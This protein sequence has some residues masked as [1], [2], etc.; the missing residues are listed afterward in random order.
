MEGVQETKS[1]DPQSQLLPR[2]LYGSPEAMKIPQAAPSAR[3]SRRG[4]TTLGATALG[5]AIALG[6]GL[7]KA[8]APPPDGL[9]PTLSSPEQGSRVPYRYQV[10]DAVVRSRLPPRLK[11]P[12]MILCHRADL[13]TGEA[14]PSYSQLAEDWSVSRRR[15]ITI[16][17]ELAE[18][19]CLQVTRRWRV[20][21]R[22]QGKP[23]VRSNLYRVQI[24]IAWTAELAAPAPPVTVE[25]EQVPDA[26]PVEELLELVVEAEQAPAELQEAEAEP[27]ASDLPMTSAPA[28]APA[29]SPEAQA[30]LE[31]LQ[32]R[33]ELRSIAT[34]EYACRFWRIAV[35]ENKSLA[36]TDRA[37]QDAANKAGNRQGEALA[38]RA[39]SFI[40]HARP[41]PEQLPST[42]KPPSPKPAQAA[43]PPPPPEVQ[44]RGLRSVLS[45]L[46]GQL[47]ELL[48]RK[49]LKPP[50]T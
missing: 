15:A 45:S 32:N 8:T 30:V 9:P 11:G 49:D 16:V 27:Q 22:Q 28:E 10:Q 12:L 6:P 5:A 39:I 20:A 40:T 3:K 38:D 17:G 43:P 2:Q 29:L 36:M 37:L 7:A 34:E 14:F 21:E 4:T 44:L 41:V 48:P 46:P 33:D 35:R 19:E 13:Y 42:I 31:I 1:D 26:E 25:A 24:P 47:T 23:H 18:A 50:D